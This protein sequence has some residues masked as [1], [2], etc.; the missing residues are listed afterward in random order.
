MEV[1]NEYDRLI[2]VLQEIMGVGTWSDC[3]ARTLN[4]GSLAVKNHSDTTI[5]NTSIN[6]P[7]LLIQCA[8][9]ST[10]KY[11]ALVDVL[12]RNTTA[13]LNGEFTKALV[14]KDSFLDGTLMIAFILCGVC[15]GSWMLFLVLL[16][17]PDNNHNHRKKMVYLGVLY[18]AAWYTVILQK[19]SSNVFATQYAGNYQN[20]SEYHTTIVET[21]FYRVMLFFGSL[22]CDLNWLNIVYYMFHNYQESHKHWVPRVLNNKNKQILV[23]G[24][25]L[26]VGHALLVCLQLWYTGRGIEVV[27]VFLEVVHFLIYTV[28]T[29]CLAYYVWHDFGFTLAPKRAEKKLTVCEQI[30]HIWRDYHEI[31]PLLVYNALTIALVYICDIALISVRCQVENWMGNLLTFLKLLITVNVWG[32]IGVLERRESTVSKQ[33]VLGRK[34]NNRDRF[35]VDPNFNYDGHDTCSNVEDTGHTDDSP[36]VSSRNTYSN[37]FKFLHRPSAALKSRVQGLRG[38]KLFNPGIHATTPQSPSG[39]N[40]SSDRLIGNAEA[41][42]NDASIHESE[43]VETFLTRNVIYDHDN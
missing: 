11:A 5:I 16:L 26:T 22:I 23:C 31:I 1:A 15:V 4:G 32:L 10:G 30:K 42:Y 8:S 17:L 6:Y 28:F 38:K 18:Q 41:F 37:V 21:N 40:H 33:T 36:Q 13:I 43:S 2:N 29:A 35:F 14:H 39:Y 7:G 19:T 24:L 3:V 25:T 20:S 12:S 27:Q 34:I 9:N